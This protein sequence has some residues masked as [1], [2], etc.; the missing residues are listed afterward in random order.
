MKRKITFASLVLLLSACA[1]NPQNTTSVATSLSFTSGGVSYSVS[2]SDAS[3]YLSKVSARTGQLPGYEL[4]AV[5][6]TKYVISLF[7]LTDNSL[8]QTTYLTNRTNYPS[9]QHT[10]FN[11]TSG[12][13][14]Y[15]NWTSSD[16]MSVTI[17]KI[18]NGMATGIFSA[19]MTQY[20]LAQENS[21]STEI[22]NGKFANIKITE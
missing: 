4:T 20:P 10:V 13:R 18:E 5:K 2:G 14:E 15:A 9:S 16:F 11:S 3:L 12:G 22:L 21:A 8:S 7:I 1:K 17:L 19:H 6:V